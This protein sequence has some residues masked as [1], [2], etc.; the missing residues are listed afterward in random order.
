MNS[1]KHK[2]ALFKCFIIDD[3]C[4]EVQVEMLALEVKIGKLL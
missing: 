2:T 1:T 3:P 4:I